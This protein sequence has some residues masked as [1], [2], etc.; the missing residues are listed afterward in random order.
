MIR[1]GAANHDQRVFEDPD[2]FDITRENARNHMAFGF[3]AHFCIGAALA[4]QQMHSAFTK[5]LAR[6]DTI[7]LDGAVPS[8]AHDPS[9]FLRP[10]TALPMALA[11]ATTIFFMWGFLTSLNDVLIPH[12]KA[13]FELNYTRAMLV[14]FTFFGAYFLMSL[15]AGRLVAHLGRAGFEPAGFHREVSV[16]LRFYITSS[17]PRLGLAHEGDREGDGDSETLRIFGWELNAA[18]RVAFA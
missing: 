5:L 17:S 15:P 3:G 14:Q 9:F 2:R 1:F 13:V 18:V 11:V 16:M 6:F 10:M 12:L 4:R 7:E 8:P